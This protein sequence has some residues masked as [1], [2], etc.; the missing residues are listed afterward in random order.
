MK[1]FTIN[2]AF[3]IL[4]VLVL[5]C[6]GFTQTSEIVGDRDINRCETKTY[7]ISLQNDS[8]YALSNLVITSDLSSLTGFSYVSGSTLI[9][10]DVDPPF[11]TEDP[12]I[13]GSNLIWDIDSLCSSSY[14]LPDGSVLNLS[15]DLVTGCTAVSG[16]LAVSSTYDL[17]GTPAT[18]DAV[19]NIQVLP[20]AVA[21]KKTPNVVTREVGQSVTWTITVENVGLGTIENVEVTDVL[22]SGLQYAS[23]TPEGVNMGQS[24][25][26]DSS[27]V[28]EFS[29]MN[30]GESITLDITAKVLA[31]GS[32][33]SHADVRWGCDET[34]DCFNTATEGGT[35]KTTVQRIVESP[36]ID[37]TPPDISFT[38]CDEQEDVDFSISNIGDATAYD[39]WIIVDFDSL[40]VSEVSS[41]A[42]FD[43][44][45]DRFELTNPIPPG[46]TY[47][48]SFKLNAGDWCGGSFPAGDLV[49]QKSYQDECG[50]EFYSENEISSIIAP[51]STPNLSV[52]LTG[53]PSVVQVGNS[54]TYQVASD[55]SGLI[56]CSTGTLDDIIVENSVPNGFMVLDD[57]GGVY[58][59]GGG[60]TGGTLTWTYTPPASLNVSVTLQ[61]SDATSCETYCYTEVMHS[62]EASVTDCCGCDLYATDSV[63]S[64]IKCMEGVV[65]NK[66][67]ISPVQRCEN[68][69]YTNTYDFASDSAVFLTDLQFEDHADHQQQFVSGSLSVIYDGS[70][71]TGCVA[72]TDNT[73][74]GHLVLDF[75][76]CAASPVA[77]KNLTISY[78]LTITENTASSCDDTSSIPGR[79]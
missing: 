11:C 29:S 38:Y 44:L 66:Y 35:A 69:N 46:S 54:I 39:V 2:R 45:N 27:Q 60:G 74:G 61:V 13:D 50:Q 18:D 42:I 64:A 19:H 23:S 20:G 7:V 26:W 55:Y 37:F 16:H 1:L 79:V 30:P 41:G 33:S 75:L 71:I 28:P 32:P 17:N 40:E 14:S 47:D 24:T 4:I 22:G 72:V 6:P 63:A 62:V 49:W 70:D 57:G 9:A 34:I 65:S 31:C 36:L 73:P 53:I 21:I 5:I 12:V 76:G 15:I 56:S 51:A 43:T 67:T 78:Q 3:I 8:G 48:L 77:N 25:I 10:Q 68:I 58:V 59:P 52:A